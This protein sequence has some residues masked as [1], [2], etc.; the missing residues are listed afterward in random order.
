VRGGV[1][2]A[3]FEM[4]C[5]TSFDITHSVADLVERVMDAYKGP[6]SF[7]KFKEVSTPVSAHNSSSVIYTGA[8]DVIIFRNPNKAVKG[9]NAYCK[10]R[11]SYVS[12]TI[13]G[14][15]QSV[16]HGIEAY[17]EKNVPAIGRR[18]HKIST[19]NSNAGHIVKRAQ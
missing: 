14:P 8:V 13:S 15:D 17:L 9:K 7:N 5:S 4:H 2:T 1:K 10:N 3:F 18:M 16:I 19:Y 12:I 11:E 6:F